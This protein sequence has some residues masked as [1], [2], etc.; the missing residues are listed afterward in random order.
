MPDV[1]SIILDEISEDVFRKLG[2][3]VNA[4]VKLQPFN[5]AVL[6]YVKANDYTIYVNSLP[7]GVVKNDPIKSK[8]Y[9]YVVL[10]HE[11]LH[12]IG[13]A[14]EREVRRITM[15]IVGQKFGEG[16]FAFSLARQ[17]SD[18]ID[19]YLGS[20]KKIKPMTYI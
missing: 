1:F 13:I 5:P 11:Y 17:L 20:N 18:P 14:D 15:E 2:K 10:L 8:E 3:R 4:I 6:G 9:L 16:S 12:L 7:Y 19:V